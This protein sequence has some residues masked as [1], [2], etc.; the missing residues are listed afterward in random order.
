MG[1]VVTAYDAQWPLRFERIA[2]GLRDALAGV[3]GVRVEHVGSTSV[4]GLA[5]KP[6]LD[7]DIL[8]S[9]AHVAAAV[10]A[11][12][13]LGYEHRGDLGMAGREAFHAPDDDPRRNV[14]VC[15]EGTL[16]VRNHLAV[17]EVL[18]RRDDLRDRYAAVKLALAADP[19]MDIDSYLAGKS[20]VLQEVLADSDLTVDELRQ[21][22]RLNDPRFEEAPDR[23]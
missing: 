15:T 6:I 11:L 9:A 22:H 16:N 3:P 4:P 7:I 17:R 14:Y 18:R 23:E 20:L 13:S 21:I 10:Q 2:V 19:A 5:A 1:I 8:V 12:E